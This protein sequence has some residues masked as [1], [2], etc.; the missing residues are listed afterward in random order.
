MIMF[1]Y[2]LLAVWGATHIIVSSKIT[3]GIRNWFLIRYPKIGYMMECY[4]CSSFWISMLFYSPFNFGF[5]ICKFYVLKFPIDIS[6]L[7]MGFIGSG[8]VTFISVILSLLI[9]ISRSRK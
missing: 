5:S 9:T 4:Q 2:Y 6:F 7:M 8:I 3:E 1:F